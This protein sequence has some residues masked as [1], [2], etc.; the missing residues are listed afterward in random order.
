MRNVDGS[1]KT[2]ISTHIRVRYVIYSNLDVYVDGAFVPPRRA[3]SEAVKPTA[4]MVR[5][6]SSL[7]RGSWKA[8]NS[9][10][11]VPHS[12]ILTLLAAL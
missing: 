2:K 5:G 1:L 10:G 9:A 6:L 4:S 8:R 7:L 3:D 12:P 11:V